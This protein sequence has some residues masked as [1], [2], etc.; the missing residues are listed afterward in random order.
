MRSPHIIKSYA[1]IRYTG[2]TIQECPSGVLSI[3]SPIHSQ[4]AHYLIRSL[5]RKCK[6]VKR[7]LASVL[8]LL[9]QIVASISVPLF[10]FSVHS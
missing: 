4:M 7:P 8:L 9:L 5:D 3:F 1:L 10:A 6:C 2:G